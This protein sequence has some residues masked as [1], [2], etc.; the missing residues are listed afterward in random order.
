MLAHHPLDPLAADGLALGTQRS[1][2]AWR[3]ISFPVVSMNP[4][5]IAEELT[6]GNLARAF[7]S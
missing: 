1:M 6:I 4:L 5:D 2:D 7:R 3:T